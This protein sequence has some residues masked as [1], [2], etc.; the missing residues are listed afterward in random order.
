[1][2][3]KAV[4]YVNGVLFEYRTESLIRVILYLM[5]YYYYFFFIKSNKPVI[6]ILF[7]DR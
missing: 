3:L 7:E 2:K 5:V 6:V 1:M 4:K